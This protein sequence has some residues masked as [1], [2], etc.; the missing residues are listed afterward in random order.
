MTEVIEIIV[1]VM[2][3]YVRE[4]GSVFIILR[5]AIGDLTAPMEVMKKAVSV[6]RRHNGLASR[7]ASVYILSLDVMAAI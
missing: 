3:R 6:M 7:V 2:K 5:D 4:T 1:T